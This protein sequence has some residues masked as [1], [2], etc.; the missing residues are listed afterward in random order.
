MVVLREDKPHFTHARHLRY[1]I[2]ELLKV[3]S[4]ISLVIT[5]ALVWGFVH[6]RITNEQFFTVGSMVVAWFFGTRK[7]KTDYKGDEK[8]GTG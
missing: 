1:A 5:A 7:Q 2:V 8:D 4:I 3:Q 6:N